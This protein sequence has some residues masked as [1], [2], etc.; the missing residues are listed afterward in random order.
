MGANH[1][2]YIRLFFWVTLLLFQACSKSVTSSRESVQVGAS[3]AKNKKLSPQVDNQIKQLLSEMTLEEKVGQLTLFTSDMDTTGPVSDSQNNEKL[4]K[5]IVE[6][7]VGSVFNAYTP[8]FTRELQTLAMEQG[9][10][11]IPLIFGYDVIHGHRTI[12]PIPLGESASWDLELIYKSARLATQEATADGIHWSFAPMVDIARDPRWGRISEGAGEDTWL[13]SKIAAARVQGIQGKSLLDTDS[14]IAC[15]KHYAAYGAPA[16]GRDYNIVNLSPLELAERYLPPYKAAI[17]AGSGSIMTAFND[18]NGVPSTSNNWLLKDLLK[19]K[20]K[21]NGFVVT[22]YTSINELVPHGVAKDLKEATY[23]SFKAGVEI[24]MQGGLFLQYLPELVNE[25]RISISEIDAAV[26]R[27]LESKFSL[28]LFDNPYKNCDDNRS[29]EVILSEEHIKHARDV[30]RKSIVL[31]KNQSQTLPLLTNKKTTVALLGPMVKN[32]RDQIGNWSAAGDWSKVTTLKE[33]L[34]QLIAQKQAPVSLLYAK[35]A[36]LLDDSKLRDFLNFHGGNIEVDTGNIKKAF[37]RAKLISQKYKSA[38]ADALD[39]KVVEDFES[40]PKIIKKI[41]ATL[42]ATLDNQ[43]DGLDHAK[44]KALEIKLKDLLAAKATEVASSLSEIESEYLS[45]EGS[46]QD[47]KVLLKEALA[48]AG[49]ADFSILALGE[50]Q[51][52]SGE[53]A[54]R[55][56][57]RIPENQKKLLRAVSK[58]YAK[59]NKRNPQN[60]KRLILLVYSG[61]PL[62]LEEEDSLADSILEV[63][64]LGTQAGPAIADVLFGDYN[65]SAK[66]TASFPYNEGQIGFHNYDQ[67][68]TGRP[69]TPYGP[70]TG[71]WV[72]DEGQVAFDKYY[73]QALD[74]RN[75]ALYPFGWG[76]SYTKFEYSNLKL[77]TKKLKPSDKLQVSF[78]VKNTGSLAGE[79]VAQL[80]LRDVVGSITRPLKELR[81]FKKVYLEAAES[82]VITFELSIE[83]LKFYNGDL[84]RIAEAGEFRVMIGGNSRDLNL[85][86]SFELSSP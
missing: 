55:S 39:P 27:V 60:P 44:L 70:V 23:L 80:Y 20:W 22:D 69:A 7:K 64:F 52:M 84:K 62:A 40:L 42:K 47:P 79:E 81:N 53:A 68:N 73:S 63:W 34:E 19:D 29:K 28:G 72:G 16:G 86:D 33:G 35:G 12:F 14:N 4:K 15:V 11:K 82:A 76:L 32:K 1:K 54:S 65:P 26:R 85:Q 17:D 9:P 45:F 57:I 51:G 67:K 3:S 61:R 50:S 83:D 46:L 30:A 38:N 74:V 10:R 66:L 24:D 2:S 13:G 48:V 43:V 31:L 37:E 18:I 8:S 49:K 59:H 77:S 6:G 78:T 5:L 21:F 75:D 71:P 25:G 56:V 41:H 58:L 36:N